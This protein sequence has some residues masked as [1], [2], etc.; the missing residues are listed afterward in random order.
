M[1]DGEKTAFGLPIYATIKKQRKKDCQHYNSKRSYYLHL[2]I[3]TGLLVVLL[4]VEVGRLF[5]GYCSRASRLRLTLLETMNTRIEG[6]T[7]GSRVLTRMLTL[8]LRNHLCTANHC[9]CIYTTARTLRFGPARFSIA[10]D[11]L[12]PK[13]TDV[14]CQFLHRPS[15]LLST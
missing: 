11:T 3:Q 12:I 13:V 2:L 10:A 15:I 6:S 9:M 14:V 4:H 8:T 7:G 5:G 1:A